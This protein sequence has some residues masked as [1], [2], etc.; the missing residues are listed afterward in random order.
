MLKDCYKTQSFS[1]VIISSKTEWLE[2][3]I[4]MEM[5]ENAKR[6]WILSVL[7]LISDQTVL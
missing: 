3:L 4:V 5:N 2:W 1:S 7:L 6:S